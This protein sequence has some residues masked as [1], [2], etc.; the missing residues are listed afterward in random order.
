MNL[1]NERHRKEENETFNKQTCFPAKWGGT[2]L[3]IYF[4]INPT[5]F[6][7]STTIF[8]CVNEIPYLQLGSLCVVYLSFKEERWFFFVDAVFSNQYDYACRWIL[9]TRGAC[10]FSNATILYGVWVFCNSVQITFFSPYLFCLLHFDRVWNSAKVYA[11]WEFLILLLNKRGT[12]VAQCYATNRKVAGS[13]TTSVSGFFIDIIL[14]II[15]WPWS[16]LSL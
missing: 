12:A 4:P 7:L 8:I 16:R 1:L 11:F 3:N 13:I 5:S 9:N 15:L 6:F 10:R 14:P 2:P